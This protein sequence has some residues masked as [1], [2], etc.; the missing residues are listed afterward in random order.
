MFIMKK[1][2]IV[3]IGEQGEEKPTNHIDE[4]P[5]HKTGAPLSCPHSL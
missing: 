5:T 2:I 3:K 1:V 4:I